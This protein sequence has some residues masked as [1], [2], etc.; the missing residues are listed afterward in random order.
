MHDADSKVTYPAVMLAE[1]MSAYGIPASA[2]ARDVVL[3]VRVW[4][5]T[6]LANNI[7][8]SGEGSAAGIV[9]D[10]APSGRLT[11]LARK[12]VFVPQDGSEM[13]PGDKPVLSAS[14]IETYLDCPYK[15]FSLRRLRLGNVDAG[16]GGMEMGTFAH[17]VLEVTHR[18]LLARSLEAQNPGKTREE[19]LARIEEN[20]VCHVPGSRVDETNLEAARLALEL[21]FN[22]HQQHM[23]M[24]KRPRQAQQLLIENNM[25]R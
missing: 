19:L 11:E 4:S 10:P 8:A 9:C 7:S 21:E 25:L 24:V 6:L 20:P 14:Q 1:L 16:H 5:E 3:P 15:W 23:Y 12:L 13:L 22:L 2:Q 18:E 17:R